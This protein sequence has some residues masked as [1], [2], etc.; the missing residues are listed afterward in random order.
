LVRALRIAPFILALAAM[1]VL[2]ASSA[3]APPAIT[4]VDGGVYGAHSWQAG[5]VAPAEVAIMPAGSVSFGYPAGVSY[6]YPVFEHGPATPTCEGL[7]HTF[8]EAGP[9]WSGS[10]AFTAAGTYEFWCGVHGAAMKAFVYVSASGTL[11]PSASTSSATAVSETE[12]TLRGSVNPKG[13]PT[14]Y[15]FEYGKTSSYEHVTEELLVGEDS[16]E[17][18]ESAS[19]SGLTLGTTYHFRIVA[20]YDSGASTV[21]GADRTFTTAS[22]PPPPPTETETTSTT[23]STTTSA[24]TPSGTT[25]T[26][27]TTTTP[28]P[29][30]VLVTSAPGTPAGGSP[31]VVAHRLTR[32]QKLAKALKACKKKPKGKRAACSRQ[33]R[34]RY[35]PKRAG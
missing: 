16:V 32:A 8:G 21:F 34:R 5:G 15:R 13:Q 23:T 30:S 3:G 24:S 22:P 11:P 19:I 6:H 20:S 29:A 28:P 27:S 2:A 14:V 31:P 17:H 35:G 10:C 26:T 1:L 7:P 12:A 33:A 4:A 18:A 9:G 25:T